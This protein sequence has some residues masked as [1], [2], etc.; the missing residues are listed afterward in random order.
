MGS[1]RFGEFSEYR[2][3]R[4]LSCSLLVEDMHRAGTARWPEK[5][6]P[7]LNPRN[8]TAKAMA[9]IHRHLMQGRLRGSRPKLDL[10]TV[11]VAAM[12]KVAIDRRVHRQRA[13]TPRPGLT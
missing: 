5:S 13:T 2:W 1:R 3:R 7:A 12:A 10:V 11:T 8:V 4:L 9:K 6:S